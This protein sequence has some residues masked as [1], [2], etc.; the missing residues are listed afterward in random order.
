MNKK[1]VKI[2]ATSF[3]SRSVRLDTELCGNPPVYTLHSQNF[4]NNKEIE[5]L[6]F[7]NIEKEN[8]CEPGYPVDLAFVNNNVGN[9]E[10]NK[11]IE[12]LSSKKLKNGKIITI[13]NTN[14]GWSYGAYNKGYEVLKSQ[15]D[16]FIFTEDDM[17][18]NKNNYAKICLETFAKNKDC[19][20]VS[21]GGV[22]S[23]KKDNLSR[24]NLIHAHGAWGFSSKEILQELYNKF[25]KLPHSEHS[26]KKDY[27][28]IIIDGE[29]KFTNAIHKMGY[30]LIETPI[31]LFHPAYDMMRGIEKP[32]KPKK[33]VAYFWM[34]KKKLRKFLFEVLVYLKLYNFYKNIRQK[35]FNF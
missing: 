29:I 2:I 23:W 33:I 7:F 22:S 25:G 3:Y 19:G 1:I 18:I 17:I 20:F 32:W 9:L 30:K 31:K 10:G 35:I 34:A 24:E 5:N 13:Q 26:E 6:I 4:T 15:Y 14:H 28:S 11:F 8:E 27:K 12:N 21:L 16:Y